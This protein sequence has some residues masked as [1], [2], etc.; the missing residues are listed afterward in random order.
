MF[1]IFVQSRFALMMRATVEEKK[2]KLT[3][4]TLASSLDDEGL[5]SPDAD[6]DLGRD[7]LERLGFGD[8]EEED[9]AKLSDIGGKRTNLSNGGMATGELATADGR[10]KRSDR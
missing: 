5:I 8:G 2:K 4:K 10:E 9:L 7:R 3:I 6:A 1:L